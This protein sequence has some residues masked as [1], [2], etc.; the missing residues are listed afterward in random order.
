VEGGGGGGRKY[1][2]LVVFKRVL[3]DVKIEL[4]NCAIESRF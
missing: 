2:F 3:E 4:V 1:A